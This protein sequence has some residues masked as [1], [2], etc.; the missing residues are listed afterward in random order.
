[1]RNAFLGVSQALVRTERGSFKLVSIYLLAQYL[2]FIVFSV[3]FVVLFS[4]YVLQLFAKP[5]RILLSLVAN[6]EIIINV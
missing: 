3:T 2:F 6:K 5:N 1:M 4:I